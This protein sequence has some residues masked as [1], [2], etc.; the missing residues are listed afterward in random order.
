MCAQKKNP[1]TP[2]KHSQKNTQNKE[3]S[4]NWT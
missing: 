3:K 1:K 2:K 4:S